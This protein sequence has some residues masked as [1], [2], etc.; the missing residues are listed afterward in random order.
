MVLT[1]ADITEIQQVEALYGHAVDWPDQSLLPKVFTK[2]AIFDGRLAGSKKSYYE[3]L[4]AIMK[5]FGQGKPP[6]PKVHNMMNVY[7]YEENGEVRV[8]AKWLVR[9]QTDSIIYMGDYEDLMERTPD[10]WRIKHRLC[11]GRDPGPLA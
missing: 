5:W 10:G 6:H 7:V 1:T 3:G 9:G 4:D 8:R 2:D 11:I